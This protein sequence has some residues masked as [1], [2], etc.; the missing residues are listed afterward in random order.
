ME[1][2]LLSFVNVGS[3]GKEMAVVEELFGV[4]MC[5]G[6]IGV[7]TDGSVGNDEACT[8]VVKGL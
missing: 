6:A 4:W 7:M 5:P 8:L 1:K 3:D 2:V